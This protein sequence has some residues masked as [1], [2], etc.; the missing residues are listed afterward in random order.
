MPFRDDREALRTRAEELERDLAAAHKELGRLQVD[1]REQTDEAAQLRKRLAALEGERDRLGGAAPRSSRPAV[2]A[3]VALLVAGAGAFLYI[4]VARTGRDESA[5]LAAERQTVDEQRAMAEAALREAQEIARAAQEPAQAP[6]PTAAEPPEPDSPRRAY[7]I[8]W[9]AKVRRAS[10]NSLRPGAACSLRGS[11]S[12]DG[13][14]VASKVD[15]VCGETVVYD[16]DAP[17]GSGMQMRSCSLVEVPGP[18]G[19]RLQYS[20]QCTDTGPRTGR[21]QLA[22]D[23]A[24]KT[25]TVWRDGGMRVELSVPA[26]ARRDGEPLLDSSVAASLVAEV[27]ARHGSVTEATAPAPVRR[28]Q[29]CAVVIV[30][31]GGECR[32]AVTCGTTSVYGGGTLGYADC[33]RENGAVVRATDSNPTGQG[34]DPIL[35]L[36]FAARR[37]T[38][39]DEAPD[40]S[41]TIALE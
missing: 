13:I 29:R 4:L 10:G 20:L 38:V 32:V 25:A 14:D 11:F 1:H 26:P 33:T 30:P 18:R 37:V 41:I 2:L 16:W 35:D 8:S 22:I 6:V 40:W 9:P 17:L 39:R 21:P 19:Q 31:A 12:T 36:D 34:G 28:G 3:L 27:V 24:A 15:V 5:R 23:T 7:D